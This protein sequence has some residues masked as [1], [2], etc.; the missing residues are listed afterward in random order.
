MRLLPLTAVLILGG[1][2]TD[3]GPPAADAAVAASELAPT[4]ARTIGLTAA[5]GVKVTGRLLEVTDARGLILLFH[6]AGSS[7]DEYATIQPHLAE[8]GYSSLAIDQRSGGDL[9]GRNETVRALG[10]TR[11]YL[12]ARADLDAAVA[13]ADA[14]P[15][16][17]PVL[18]WGSSYSAALV[19]LV[20]ADHADKV[21]G[22]LAFSPGEYLGS[23]R[24]VRDAAAR[25]K[26]P[27]FVTAASDAGELKAARDIAAAVQGGATLAEPKTGVHGSSTLIAARN[28]AGAPAN[29]MAVERFLASIRR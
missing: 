22:V 1:C 12:E 29:W 15:G 24:L 11:D 8:L 26:A 17:A 25:V 2:G 20:A 9:F 3:A 5:D 21:A 14:R 23:P 6:Q 28:A 27:V 18:L 16:D 13:W 4:A 7:K 10:G 19:F